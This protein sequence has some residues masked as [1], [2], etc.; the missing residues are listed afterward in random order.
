MKVVKMLAGV[1][2]LGGFALT[3]SP[4][5]AQAPSD[6]PKILLHVKAATTKNPCVATGVTSCTGATTVGNLNP[7]LYHVQVL[8][9]PWDSLTAQDSGLAG[10][11]FGL[12]YVGGVN[13]NGDPSLAID[14]FG[15]TLCATLEFASPNP[16]WP[17]PGSGNLITWD[18]VNAC[19]RSATSTAGYFY[20][21]AYMPATLKLMKRAS[22]NAAKVADCGSQEVAL[23]TQELGWASFSAGASTPGCNPC[24]TPC[25]MVAVQPST[26][27][28]IKALNR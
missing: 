17:A 12:D 13:S 28:S 4:A 25:G 9:A 5:S 21:T 1:L 14:I 11:Q 3:A 10:V 6:S 7:T 15:W 22:D 23:E 2:V 27:S 8:V 20:L 19:Q 16:P 24:L 26:W 18:A